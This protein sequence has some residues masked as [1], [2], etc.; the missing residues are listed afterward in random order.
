MTDRRKPADG[1]CAA[2]SSSRTAPCSAPPALA[3]SGAP[4]IAGTQGATR[5]GGFGDA[6]RRR[7]QRRSIDSQAQRLG[8]D[9]SL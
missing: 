3:G 6:L 8:D 1:R 4:G 9:R 2:P 7:A 5:A